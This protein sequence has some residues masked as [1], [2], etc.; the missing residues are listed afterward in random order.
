MDARIES[1]LRDEG[2]QGDL[3]SNARERSL[4]RTRQIIYFILSQYFKY[5][6]IAKMMDC[7]HMTAYRGSK[8]IEANQENYSQ[9][10][11]RVKE[12]L[13]DRYD[14]P[15]LGVPHFGH[16]EKDFPLTDLK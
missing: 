11:A 9:L 2:F 1:Y 3:G 15:F 7:S 16:Y 10:I 8:F 6:S 4:V 12:A 14:F 5:R 13:T